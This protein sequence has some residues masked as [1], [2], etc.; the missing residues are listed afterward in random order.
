MTHS[1]TP[2]HFRNT[3]AN[4]VNLTPYFNTNNYVPVTNPNVSVSAANRTFGGNSSSSF[5]SQVSGVTGPSRGLTSAAYLNKAYLQFERPQRA[6]A[7]LRQLQ[8]TTYNNSYS[9]VANGYFHRTVA[10]GEQLNSNV[11]GPVAEPT[12]NGVQTTPLF[13]QNSVFV[14]KGANVG[15]HTRAS[16]P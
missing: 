10:Y 4:P 13:N 9:T 8:D 15:S 2:T 11:A 5:S 14:Q 16:L 7:V 1:R 12:P 3:H 6:L